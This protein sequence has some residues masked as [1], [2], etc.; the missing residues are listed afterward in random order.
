MRTKNTECKNCHQRVKGNYCSHCGQSTDT[1]EINM[2]YIFHEIQHGVLHVDKGIFYTIKELFRRPGNTIREYM[3]GKRVKHF[4]PFAFVFILATLYAL[5]AG[6][7]HSG[8]F[9][10]GIDIS[11]AN[12]GNAE[13]QSKGHLILKVFSWARSHYAYTTILILPFF[14]LASYWLFRKSRRNYFQHLV[15]NA[16][17]TGQRTLIYLLAIPLYYIFTSSESHEVIGEVKFLAGLLLTFWAYY[18]FFDTL[19][20][21]KRILF[22]LLTYLLVLVFLLSIIILTAVLLEVF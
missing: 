11:V 4:K 22:T 21:Y 3:D 10:D 9:L 5:L 14:A 6:I 2:A 8:T 16:Y 12:T 19:K 7:S 18:Q 13:S 15:L 1:H 17:V 20:P